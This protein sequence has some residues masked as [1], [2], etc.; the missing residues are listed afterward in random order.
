M[1]QF[2]RQ[3]FVRLERLMPI[4]TTSAQGPINGTQRQIS[5]NKNESRFQGKAVLRDK[6]EVE[7]V[8]DS[9]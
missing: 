1:P 3:L 2:S 9:Y 6:A 4:D 5:F 8:P 7:I